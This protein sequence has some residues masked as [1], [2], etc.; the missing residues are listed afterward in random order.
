M[1][2][3]GKWNDFDEHNSV[4]CCLFAHTFRRV[5]CVCLAILK[6]SFLCSYNTEMER[7]A[8]AP[9]FFYV[10]LILSLSLSGANSNT[11]HRLNEIIFASVVR[12]CTTDKMQ[13]WIKSKYSK[14]L[15]QSC[16]TE[17]H[18]MLRLCVRRKCSNKIC[19]FFFLPAFSSVFIPIIFHAY[20]DGIYVE[21]ILFI[22]TDEW[23]RIDGIL[24]KAFDG[25]KAFMGTIRAHQNK[26][27]W[28]IRSSRCR[29]LFFSSSTRQFC[30]ETYGRP[31]L[32]FR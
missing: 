27:P 2:R 20:Y 17:F 7:I 19:L 23:A 18:I 13:S 5:L 3:N 6:L 11:I 21:N 10:W 32:R 16:D 29:F 9:F 14:K 26:S 15:G 12:A 28:M 4:F 30:T 31:Y 1:R 25:T 22:G 8:K 24:C